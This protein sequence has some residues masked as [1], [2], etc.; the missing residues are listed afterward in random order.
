ME[1]CLLAKERGSYEVKD[2]NTFHITLLGKW[3][4]RLGTE[5]SDLWKDVLESK[6]GSWRMLDS[7]EV[8]KE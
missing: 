4:C 1:K 6:Y 8:T 5:K 3:K 2:I 7:R